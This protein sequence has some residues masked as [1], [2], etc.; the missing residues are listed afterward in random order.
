M[1]E[2]RRLRERSAATI[3][4]ALGYGTGAAQSTLIE[5]TLVDSGELTF[6]RTTRSAEVISKGRGGRG[7]AY[8]RSTNILQVAPT[9]GVVHKHHGRTPLLRV[10]GAHVP[11]NILASC[12][13][14]QRFPSFSS[15]SRAGRV[16][17]GNPWPGTA[18]VSRE[19]IREEDADAEVGD[20]APR[21]GLLT[22]E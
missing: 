18:L 6:D 22:R 12:E 16:A 17:P 1:G 19:G 20:I 10:P 13:P 14:R 5:D 7:H 4:H 3:H 9:V 2:Q 11:C 21:I 8:D 15:I